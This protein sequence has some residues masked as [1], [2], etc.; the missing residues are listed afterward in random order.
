MIGI[1]QLKSILNQ[2]RHSLTWSMGSL[3]EFQVFWSIVV[4]NPVFVVNRFGETNC[5][6]ENLFHHQNMLR[7]VTILACAR[8]IGHTYE[9][10]AIFRNES[11][12]II[13][14]FTKCCISVFFPSPV[15]LA[16][17]ASSNC[18]VLTTTNFAFAISF[19]SNVQG[20]AVPTE[21]TKVS[22]AKAT[23]VILL[24]ASWHATFV[25]NDAK[26]ATAERITVS[27]EAVKMQSAESF[28]VML[29]AAILNGTN[30]DRSSWEWRTGRSM[31]ADPLGVHPA[32]P[33]GMNF[34]VTL[35]NAAFGPHDNSPTGL[36]NTTVYTIV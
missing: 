18:L 26:R 7:N 30:L 11:F 17:H 35:F 13:G 1:Q 19:R 29:L 36:D 32:M 5:P 3:P 15:V 12:S 27:F 16:T 24:I 28:R 31:N 10:V 8:M 9:N 6:A 21:L 2:V 25:I 34:P 20:I 33:I 23:C 4:A 22:G 14:T